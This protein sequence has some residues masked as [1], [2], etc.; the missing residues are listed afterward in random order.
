[1]NGTIK[2]ICLVLMVA[3]PVF[4]WASPPVLTIELGQTR[5]VDRLNVR[6][7]L[8]GNGTIATVRAI[9]KQRALVVAQAIGETEMYFMQANGQVNT[10]K[11]RV[12]PTGTA[13]GRW[14]CD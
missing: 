13:G 4:G 11:L 5:L 14:C 1:M 3:L 8:L 9:D 6:E 2:Q 12:L 10:A 7:I